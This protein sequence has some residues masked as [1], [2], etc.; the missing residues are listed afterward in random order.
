[1][2]VRS[3]D[4]PR[5]LYFVSHPI[6]YQAPMIKYLAT[7]GDVEMHVVFARDDGLVS[8]YDPDFQ[9][10]V[11]WDI[12]LTDGY[13]HEFLRIRSGEATS[14]FIKLTE[15]VSLIQTFRRFRPDAV[16]VHGYDSRFSLALLAACKLTRVPLLA[17]ADVEESDAHGGPK[18]RMVKNRLLRWYFPHISGFLAVGIRNAKFYSDRGVPARKIFSTPYGIDNV[19]FQQT[20]ESPASSE[21]PTFL[22]AG[23]LIPRKR[24]QDA[25]EALRRVPAAKL[26]FVGSG[27]L[28]PMLRQMTEDYG[29]QDR[30][31][32]AG[33][34]NQADIVGYYQ[35]AAALLLI[36]ER[37]RWGLVANEAM[38]AGCPVISYE[39]VGCSHD[40]VRDQ[41]TGF[42][43]DTG[44]VPQLAE[45]MT[46]LLDPERQRELSR[47]AREHVANYSFH[48]VA[49]GLNDSLKSLGV[50]TPAG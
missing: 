27:E 49:R 26:I 48:D 8:Y 41:E 42:V 39:A 31:T 44:N 23:K 16:W 14:R 10:S 38:A 29:L 18:V 15:L 45:A 25:I 11:A 33:F 43:V 35:R 1:M 22:F 12:P 50:L 21:V 20:T 28:E 34:V 5:V 32:F 36:S 37:E 30:V 24:P 9:K 40:L 6:P 2:P 3:G 4:K 47:N 17:R 46:K 7:T 13:S 19:R